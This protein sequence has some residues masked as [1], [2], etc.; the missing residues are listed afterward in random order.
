M[1]KDQGLSSF[2]NQSVGDAMA[3][4]FSL[5][6]PAFIRICEGSLPAGIFLSAA[7]SIQ[8]ESEKEGQYEWCCEISELQ[9]R[10]MLGRC[11]VIDASR[12]LREQGLITSARQGKPPRRYY[13]LNWA[14]FEPLWSEHTGQ[15]F[16]G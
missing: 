4:G 7:I 16:F 13:A 5:F 14:I 12:Y 11:R 10:L 8:L 9:Q 15:R 6:H 2:L 3:D 1:E